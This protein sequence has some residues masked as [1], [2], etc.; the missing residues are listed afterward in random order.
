MVLV[1]ELSLLKRINVSR[2][3]LS[4]FNLGVTARKYKSFIHGYK[5][6][7]YFF[8]DVAIILRMST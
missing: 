3:P 2:R 5:I 6:R 8:L 1:N 7:M 4:K